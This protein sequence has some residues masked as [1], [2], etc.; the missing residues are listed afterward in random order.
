MQIHLEQ[1][2]QVVAATAESI[3]RLLLLEVLEQQIL[4]EV[5]EVVEQQHIQ[6]AQAS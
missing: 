2:D 1:V 5:V 3:H 4:E 6:A